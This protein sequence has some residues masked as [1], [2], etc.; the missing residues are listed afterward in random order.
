MR[1]PNQ[2]PRTRFGG[3]C[4]ALCTSEQITLLSYVGKCEP[5]VP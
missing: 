3:L 2:L 1:I 5:G 4:E